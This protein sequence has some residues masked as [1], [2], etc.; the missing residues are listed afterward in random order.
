[1]AYG[2]VLER[3]RPRKGSGGSNPPLSSYCMKYKLADP[4]FQLQRRYHKL[5]NNLLGLQRNGL[6]NALE[7]RT[8]EL[9]VGRAKR[10]WDNAQR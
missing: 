4:V 10:D 2:T 3:Q 6:V 9:E 5:L 1:M 8:M 7:Q